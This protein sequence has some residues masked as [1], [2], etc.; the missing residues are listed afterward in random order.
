MDFSDNDYDL[1]KAANEGATLTLYHPKT[2][3]P[4][5]DGDD[6]VT[7]T[8]KGND[9]D[10]FKAALSDIVDAHSDRKK[11]KLAQAETRAIML[12]ARVTT[13]W[14]GIDWEGKPLEF[15]QANA[16]MLY[17]ARPWIRQQVDEFVQE[18]ANFGKGN[19]DV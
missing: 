11:G 4:F 3:E 13:D 16:R 17:R 1:T 14:S 7:I 6:P 19:G 15:T 8:V 18:K 9:S 5:Y 2:Q 12:M 10:E